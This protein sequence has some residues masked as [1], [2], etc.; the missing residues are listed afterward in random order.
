MSVII[1][2][3]RFKSQPQYAAPIDYEGLGKG[4]QILFNPALGPV[5]LATGRTWTAG[6]DAKIES[7][8]R[9]KIFRY[10]GLDGDLSYTGYSEISGT[11]GTFFIWCPTVGPEDTFGHGLFGD[12]D[13]YYLEHNGGRFYHM[14]SVSDITIPWFG[15]IN[16]S[17]VASSKGSTGAGLKLYLNGKDSGATFSGDPAPW[18]AGN[19]TI[20]LGRYV[21]GNS[22]DF[23]GS[24]LIAGYTKAVWGE[25]EAKAFHENPNLVFKAQ[26]RRLWAASSGGTS[27]TLPAD[28]GS[29][30]LTGTAANLE[31]NRLLAAAQ[32]SFAVTA[33]AATLKRGYA[34]Q[35]AS[36]S[37]T[38]SGADAGLKHDRILQAGS[39]SSQ[40]AGTDASLEY[41][42]VL[43]ADSAAF[44][45]V[46]TD[47]TFVHDAP[48]NYTLS[49]DSGSFGIAAQPATLKYNRRLSADTGSFAFT[50]TAASLRY[51]RAVIAEAAVFALTGTDA[52]FRRTG[53]PEPIVSTV[54][55]TAIFRAAVERA[56]TFQRSK[57]VNVR[58][59]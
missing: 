10:P 31:Y 23:N 2:P 43:S 14:A 16:G 55:R 19:R 12:A 26:R 5:D 47:A 9:G 6:G 49:A 35:A 22:W 7:G 59:N 54:E 17:M 32:G 42:R 40:I 39:A 45:I 38:L 36:G 57:Q 44:Q 20:T 25:A 41:S 52:T 51:A 21:G 33:N 48:G 37:F 53:G 27:Y 11:V 34:L 1:L 3:R 18:G 8:S 28:S 24:I 56:T 29:F 13:T 50:G 46:G 30:A 15:T 4:V 58:F